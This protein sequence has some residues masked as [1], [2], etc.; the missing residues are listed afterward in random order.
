MKKITTLILIFTPFIILAQISPPQIN[1]TAKNLCNNIP[2]TLSATGC[3]GNVIWKNGLT[4]Q[5][6]IVSQA[7]TYTARCVVNGTQSVDSAPFV[8]SA[9]LSGTLNFTGQNNCSASDFELNA[10]SIPIGTYPQFY[11]DL[12]SGVAVQS[13][14]IKPS[15]GG[16]YTFKA[17]DKIVGTWNTQNTNSTFKI[18]DIF[19]INSNKGWAVG[20]GGRIYYTINGGQTWSTSYVSSTVELKNVHFV[21]EMIGW[22]VGTTGKVYKTTN[23]GVSWVSITVNGI[24]NTDIVYSVYFVDSNTG[25]I[26][27]SN[28]VYKTVNAG[29]SWTQESVM[30]PGALT[31]IY[32]LNNTT[33]W[34]LTQYSDIHKTINSGTTWTKLNAP[35]FGENIND[36]HFIN[37]NFG[38]IVGDKG[39]LAISTDGGQTWD[40]QNAG[41][42]N[43][44]KKVRFLN[45]SEGWVVGEGGLVLHTD[46]GGRSWYK[47]TIGLTEGV[48]GLSVYD[49]NSVWIASELGKIKK[50]ESTKKDYCPSNSVFI[51]QSP[52]RPVISKL[53]C[54]FQ[55]TNLAVTNCSGAVSWSNGLTT[56]TIQVNQAGTYTAKC[57]VDGCSSIES[58]SMELLFN[59]SLDFSTNTNCLSNSP[60]LLAS[61]S[62]GN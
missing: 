59:N 61:S 24:L 23:G 40:T 53:S 11:K 9:N 41:T 26:S 20:S 49:A 37:S 39:F 16:L 51:K 46:D 19:F 32:F 54:D 60:I 57:K 27:F 62:N 25:W 3:N 38:C 55:S 1:G 18:N 12:Q 4:G 8:V 30:G 2:I 15:E 21:S 58:K 14:K 22:C 31:D 43:N 45:D 29:I 7:G 47:Q 36:I 35:T 17:F 10:V 52:E 13:V 34:I 6:I 28:K 48:L 5:S 56:Q 50:F 33:G 42:L 44:L